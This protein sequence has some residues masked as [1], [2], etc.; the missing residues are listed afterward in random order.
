MAI[1]G[2]TKRTSAARQPHKYKDLNTTADD[3]ADM[4][5]KGEMVI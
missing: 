1:K 3:K 4:E 2:A 5:E